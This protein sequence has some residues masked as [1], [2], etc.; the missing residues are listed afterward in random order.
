MDRVTQSR[1]FL[2]VGPRLSTPPSCDPDDGRP[3]HSIMGRD[4]GWES[5]LQAT[6]GLQHRK[7]TPKPR[8][9][10]R[11]RLQTRR[12]VRYGV[13]R[14]IPNQSNPVCSF[15]PYG[16]A[17]LM[18]DTS[19]VVVIARGT[20]PVLSRSQI[21]LYSPAGESLLILSVRPRPDHLSRILSCSVQTVGSRQSHQV[22]LDLRRTI[23]C[24]Q[25]GRRL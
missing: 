11:G 15:A 16:T 10:R 2:R 14:N 23:G 4:A 22:R 6:T 9:F 13:F 3:S 17:A 1:N 19:K 18:R 7:Q 21:Q 5:L 20:V 12:S 24:A 8:R 25:R